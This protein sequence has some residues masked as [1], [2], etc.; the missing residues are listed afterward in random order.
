MCFLVTALK[1]ELFIFR[2]QQEEADNK[3]KKKG[4]NI[5]LM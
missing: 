5:P 4:W 2:N 3:Q 1:V